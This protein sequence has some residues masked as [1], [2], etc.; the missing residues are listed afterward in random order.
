VVDVRGDW[1]YI[2]W[3]SDNPIALQVDNYYE[4]VMDLNDLVEECH[5]RGIYVIAR[6][7]MFKDNL[8][9]STIT[10]WAIKAPADEGGLY[11]DYEG[12]TWLDPYLPEVVEYEADLISE[13]LDFGFDEIQMD[14][15]RF[16]SDGRA[17]SL[18]YS[19]ES[20]YETRIAAI[21][22]FTSAIYDIVEPSRAFLSADVFGM[23][24]WTDVDFDMG[25]GQRIEDIAPNVDYI[26]PMLYPT[27]FAS[28]SVGYT[29]PALY[30]YEVVYYSMVE[31]EART[32][33]KVRPWLQHYSIYGYSY[34]TYELL[35][36]RK[37]AEDGGGCGWM[38]WNSGALYNETVMGYDPYSAY[39]NLPNLAGN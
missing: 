9:A 25:I 6:M 22:S 38:F 37:A 4:G 33:T 39:P 28:G 10:D 8:V 21:E 23:T 29:E 31:M 36:E 35:E 17:F 13:V 27:T 3:K 20:E 26:S 24:P 15:L 19:Q 2:A 16:P 30:P 34:D 5:N 1:S 18:I 11:Y 32:S 12:L 14:Y 7:V